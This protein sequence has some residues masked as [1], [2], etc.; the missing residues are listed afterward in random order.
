MP[1]GEGVSGR[2]RTARREGI[3]RKE[4]SDPAASAEG[5]RTGTGAT[6][7]GSGGRADGPR[8]HFPQAILLGE[9]Q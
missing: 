1:I 9:Q 2:M 3:V 8:G 6:V 4:P 5:V 7:G